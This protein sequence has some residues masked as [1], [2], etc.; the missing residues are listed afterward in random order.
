VDVRAHETTSQIL[1]MQLLA[2]SQ[3]ETLLRI[4]SLGTFWP[5]PGR[6][7]VPA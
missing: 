2:M 7:T 4:S 1:G 6:R 3:V 5:K